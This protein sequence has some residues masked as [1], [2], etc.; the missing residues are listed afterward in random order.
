MFKFSCLAAFVASI[1]FS[2]PLIPSQLGGDQQ[3][4]INDPRVPVAVDQHTYCIAGHCYY[5]PDGL[6]KNEIYSGIALTILAYVFLNRRNLLFWWKVKLESLQS[7]KTPTKIYPISKLKPRKNE[8]ASE[9]SVEDFHSGL[10]APSG[11]NL[12]GDKKIE[13]WYVYHN[14]KH[15]GPYEKF[16]LRSFEKINANSLV[17]RAGERWQRAGDIPELLDFLE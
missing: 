6:T 4:I 1:A 14:G 9:S 7:T 12:K 16:Q 13:A 5:N 10:I 3:I 15:R 17:R 11:S 2:L 8:S